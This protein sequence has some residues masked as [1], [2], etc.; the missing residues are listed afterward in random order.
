MTDDRPIV[1]P[2]CPN[3]CDPKFVMWDYRPEYKRWF[4][5]SCGEPVPPIVEHRWI[6]GLGGVYAT[7]ATCDHTVD[8]I[9]CPDGWPATCPRCG[10]KNVR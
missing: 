6:I 8:I 7:C 9:D 3:G 2:D 4:C 1:K 5:K 10:S